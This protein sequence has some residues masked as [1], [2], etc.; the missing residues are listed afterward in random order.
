MGTIDDK[1]PDIVAR[2]DVSGKGYDV[3]DFN[4][5]MERQNKLVIGSI[6]RT[7][8]VIIL[9]EHACSWKST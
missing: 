2:L 1:L 6:Y 9:P 4:L 8:L 3:T 7:F 5:E